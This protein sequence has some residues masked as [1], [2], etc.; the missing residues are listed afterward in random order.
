MPAALHPLFL[1]PLG[2]HAQ[3]SEAQA[4]A[5]ALDRLVFIVHGRQ[6]C[7][8]TRALVEKTLAKDE[9]A[10]MVTERFVTV[11]S[12]ADQPN[13]VVLGLVDT[14]PV[15][16]PTPL[17]L[18]VTF[19]LRILHSTAGGRPAAVLLNDMLQACSKRR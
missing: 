12:D 7:G 19:D 11:A 5:R 6:S 10:Q 2:W 4:E 18:Y 8:G 1:S 9:I 13:E 17:C 14:L 15:K 16:T 3:L